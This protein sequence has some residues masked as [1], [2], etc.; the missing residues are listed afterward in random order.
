M[1]HSRW[2][3]SE[4]PEDAVK[5]ETFTVQCIR[6]YISAIQ[7][8]PVDECAGPPT[9]RLPGDDAGLLAAIGLIRLGLLGNRQNALLQAVAILQHLT[10]TSPFN[11]EAVVTLLILYTRIGAGWLA[12]E[13]YSRLSIK[14]IQFPTL[15]WLLCTRLSSIHPHP[16]NIKFN[17]QS[18]K[19]D[20]D[21]TEHLSRALDYQLH[22]RETDQQET[23]DFLEAG[24]YASLIQAMGNSIFNQL[25]FTKYMLL[26]E[27]ARIERLSGAQPKLDFQSLSSELL[28]FKYPRAQKVLT[29]FTDLLPVETIDNRD[30]S[31][32][33][34]WEAPDTVS[35]EEILL[36]GK[37]PS[38]AFPKASVL[39]P[40]GQ[41]TSFASTNGSPG[42]PLL[43][44]S[45]R[46]PHKQTPLLGG[47]MC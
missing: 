9:E 2:K 33:P 31:P 45:P 5:L 39:F 29:I 8:Y 22:L 34:H 35:L 38:V 1:V 43:R 12:A 18:E 25:G 13:C 11:Y 36:P 20:A 47:M 6:A 3:E 27:W 10:Q 28:R 4:N 15:S 17:S 7:S 14:N 42:K 16:P 30:R 32:I 44:W 37:W 19:V 26:V 41:L 46:L 40:N 21:P 24:Q 23:H